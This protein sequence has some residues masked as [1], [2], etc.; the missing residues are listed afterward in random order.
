MDLCNA[1]LTPQLFVLTLEGNESQN[2]QSTYS[3]T[4]SYKHENPSEL[5]PNW[6]NIPSSPHSG[7]WLRLRSPKIAST[8]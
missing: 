4:Q 1:H 7:S 2:S 3:Y 6:P 8:K 5:V